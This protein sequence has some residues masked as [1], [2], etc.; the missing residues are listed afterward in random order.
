MIFLE[1]F[2]GGVHV[3]PGEKPLKPIIFHL[4]HHPRGITRQHVRSAFAETL[5]PLLKDSRRLLITV[6]RPKNIKDR[7]SSTRLADLPGTNPSDYINTG[8]ITRSP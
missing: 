7:I 2:H 5:G 8:D 4:K 1:Y 6:S 3:L